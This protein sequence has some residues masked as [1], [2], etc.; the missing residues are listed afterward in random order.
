MKFE[1]TLQQRDQE[2]T[3]PPAGKEVPQNREVENKVAMDLS[4]VD[5][6]GTANLEDTQIEDSER[7]E[8]D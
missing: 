2:I 4:E 8:E 7:I 6:G 1:E 5:I 3:G